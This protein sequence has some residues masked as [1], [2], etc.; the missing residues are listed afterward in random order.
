MSPDLGITAGAYSLPKTEVKKRESQTRNY[1]TIRVDRTKHLSTISKNGA[2]TN[3]ITS[4]DIYSIRREQQRVKSIIDTTLGAKTRLKKVQDDNENLARS[5]AQ[6][7][8]DN[9]SISNP[10]WQSVGGRLSASPNGGGLTNN[11]NDFS[12]VA[13]GLS[14]RR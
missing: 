3:T 14:S 7:Y 12:S 10:D 13:N 6:I 8:G 2:R 5:V 1:D 9:N 11:P 4:P